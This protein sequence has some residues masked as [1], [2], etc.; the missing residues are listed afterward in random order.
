MFPDKNYV[1]EYIDAKF[2][3]ESYCR[4]FSLP[5]WERLDGFVNCNL[6]FPYTKSDVPGKI[7]CSQFTDLSGIDEQ[8]TADHND[9]NTQ[10]TKMI[11]LH[12][13]YYSFIKLFFRAVVLQSVLS[14]LH[15]QV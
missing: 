15:K 12:K 2:Q 10:K 4:R 3:S 5:F 6:W 7:Y 14:M 8:I 11:L 13:L 1:K 9:N